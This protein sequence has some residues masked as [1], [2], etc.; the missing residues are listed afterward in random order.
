MASRIDHRLRQQVL[1]LVQAAAAT[2][3]LPHFRKLQPGGIARKTNA[4]D[5]V[6]EAD[7]ASE[8]RIAEGLAALVPGIVIIGEEAVS[9]DPRLLDGLADAEIAAI[10]D[11]LDGTW[12]F[13]RG[14]SLFG[15][16]L[17]IVEAG[18]TTFGLHFDPL[19]GDW[20][21]AR[22]GE[23]AYRCTA[24]GI[25]HKLTVKPD[26]PS[27]VGIIPANPLPTTDR[28]RLA[29]ATAG[30]DRLMALGCSCHEYW[31]LAEGAADFLFADQVKP[32]DHAAGVLIYT[33]A[34]GYA[35]CL[36]D[37]LPY[38]PAQ[39]SLS[40]ICARNQNLWQALSQA[41]GLAPRV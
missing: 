1:A 17:A 3:I 5:L 36:P 10:V 12:N 22:R 16:N 27:S 8:H 41:I 37:G 9:E 11:P 24:S 18:V 14:L 32:W 38:A 23:G 15:I 39:A 28:K 21:E 4:H 40:L 13:A 20:I 34:G 25:R 26:V 35:E 31:L 6:T 30:L 33:E 29:E 19:T 2:D 7:K